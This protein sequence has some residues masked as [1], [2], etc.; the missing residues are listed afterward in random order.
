MPRNVQKTS[1]YPNPVAAIATAGTHGTGLRKRAN[2][3]TTR[4][5]ATRIAAPRSDTTPE[6]TWR[7]RTT[8]CRPARITVQPRLV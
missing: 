8:S 3:R 7:S 6:T 1:A 2:A 4:S 5:W